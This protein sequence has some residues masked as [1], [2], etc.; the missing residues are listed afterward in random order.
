MSQARPNIK[1]AG[2]QRA[3]IWGFPLLMLTLHP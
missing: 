3:P 1:G 2:P